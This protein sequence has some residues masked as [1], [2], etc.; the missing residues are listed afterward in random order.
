MRLREWARQQGVS[1]R[2]ALNWFHNGTLPAPAQ[3]LPSGTI[4]VETESPEGRTVAYCPTFHVDTGDEVERR[5]GRVATACSN[6]GISLHGTTIEKPLEGDARPKLRGLL[7]DPGVSRI[8]VERRDHIAPTGVELIQAALSAAG[9]SILALD[10]EE[11]TESPGETGGSDETEDTDE[12][13]SAPAIRT[14][15][16]RQ[17]PAKLHDIR[18]GPSE[19]H[20]QGNLDLAGRTP[21][22]AVVGTRKAS[23][24]C[25]NATRTVAAE[26]AEAGIVVVSGLAAGVDT[27]AHEAAIAAGG[28][29]IAVLGTGLNR[30][31]PA[32]N[33]ELQ[34]RIA[35]DHLVL[36]Q[37]PPDA[38]PTRS[39]FPQRNAVVTAISDAVIIVDA[40]DQSGTLIT[41]RRA[42]EQG[43]PVHVPR[44]LDG[45]RSW[46]ADNRSRLHLFDDTT[47]VVDQLAL[48]QPEGEPQQQRMFDIA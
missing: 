1:Y 3:Q 29:T 7:A 22:V 5:A 12:D 25:L 45:A 24:A 35:R 15:E 14:V 44:R 18:R 47:S 16:R 43:R 26:L 31:Y 10:E 9:R 2:T 32:S 42:F 19:L 30:T 11:R 38:G 27:A 36:S 34:Q 39:S 6:H 23:R 40:G 17:M 46:V 41:M 33:R 48:P 4:L 13:D 21:A 37:F 20:Y 28:D 8:V